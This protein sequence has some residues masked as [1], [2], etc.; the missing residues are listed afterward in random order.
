[1]E[2]PISTW[3]LGSINFPFGGGGYLRILPLSYTRRA[4]RRVN[5]H[6]KKPAIVY[7]HPWE[8]DPE[9]PKLKLSLRSRFRHYT[10]LNTMRDRIKVLLRSYRFV[11]LNELLG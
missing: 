11:P 2:L 8:I 3:R 1:M 4:F 6:E 10:N 9:Q 7:F 5:D